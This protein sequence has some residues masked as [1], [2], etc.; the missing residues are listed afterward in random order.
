MPYIM[1]YG[2]T[3]SLNFNSGGSTTWPVRNIQLQVERASLDV[4]LV[5]DWREK[6]VPGR[7]RRTLS[8][9]LLA[10][11]AAT[12][13][14]VREHIYPT[15]LANAVNRSVVVAFSD[16]AGKAYTITGHITAASRTDDGT[17]AAVWSLSV[18]EA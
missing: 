13:D 8:F 5:S 2:G 15:S 4:T 14:P 17:G 9:D 11:D 18:D 10:Q 7:V 6:R 1:G 12:D 3:V 16:Q